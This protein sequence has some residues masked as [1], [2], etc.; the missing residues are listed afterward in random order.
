MATPRFLTAGDTVT[1]SAITHNYLNSDKNARISLEVAGA[2]LLDTA[3][4]S[5][6]IAKQ[7]EHRVDWRVNAPESGE[8]RLLAKSLTDEESD[9]IEL[10]I[11]IHPRGLET[12]ARRSGR[13][14]G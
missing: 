14:R 12:D 11:P 1:L 6:N 13:P 8:L 7:G 9:A 10:T 5:A 2:R 3:Q 4:Q